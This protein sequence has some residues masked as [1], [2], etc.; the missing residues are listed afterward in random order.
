M[1]DLSFP[2]LKARKTQAEEPLGE[3]IM[4]DTQI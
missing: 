2:C 4:E 3:D 1:K